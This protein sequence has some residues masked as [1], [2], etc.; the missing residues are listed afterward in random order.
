LLKINPPSGRIDVQRLEWY[1]GSYDKGYQ[2]VVDVLDLSDG[3][4]ALVSVQ[5]S[6]VLIVHNLETGAKKGAIDL[7]GRG[8]NPRMEIRESGREIWASDYDTLV[9]LRTTDWK[10]DRS[11]L[12]QSSASGSQQFIGDFTFSPDEELCVIARPFSGD[13]VGIDLRS[14]KIKY[15]AKVGREPLE[16]A[17]IGQG[18][19]VARDW[20]TGSLLRGFLKRRWFGG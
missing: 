17:P 13:V 18:E 16:V 1:D 15:S 3:V 10:V 19:I 5:R 7:G 20:K 12:V 4:S 2:G 14:L 9:V 11:S 6:S 8:G